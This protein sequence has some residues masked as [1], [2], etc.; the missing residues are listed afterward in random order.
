[1]ADED[2]SKGQ[3]ISMAQAATFLNRSPSWVQ[4]LVTQGYI[5]RQS[6]GRYSVVAMVR[7]ALAYYEDLL[8]K[9]TKA[10]A[11]SRATA[12]RTREIELRIAERRRDLI[13][14]EDAKAELA[15]VV[16]EVR[17][18]IAGLGARITRDLELRRQIDR[19]ADGIL[20]RLAE[21]AEQASRALAVEGGPV[22]AEPEA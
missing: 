21:R 20:G 12:A 19:E 18:E 2:K 5:T 8:Q 6:Y 13:P 16:S 14:M 3:T 10:A 7:G 17:A 15:A 1:M 22:E 4:S 9:S 11:A